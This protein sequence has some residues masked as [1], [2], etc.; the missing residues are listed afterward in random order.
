[1]K[2]IFV[3]LLL[4]VLMLPIYAQISVR[5]GAGAT[6][7]SM[8]LRQPWDLLDDKVVTYNASVSMDYLQRKYFYLSSEFK[9]LQFGGDD[10]ELYS[11][12]TTG[13]DLKGLPE[14]ET[15]SYLQLNTKFRAR[16]P[17]GDYS[18]YAGIGPH[19]NLLAGNRHFNLRDGF[20]DNQARKFL[21]GE[22]FELGLTYTYNKVLFD[23]NASYQLNNSPIVDDAPYT[24]YNRIWGI[25]LSVGYIF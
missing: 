12:G 8:T 19:A 14:P 13:H 15:W 4:G 17:Y 7:S 5:V 24:F 16:I 9:Y 3:F 25:N 20:G 18:I 11:I 1:M 6:I 2:K 23:L 10:H 22:I 21:W